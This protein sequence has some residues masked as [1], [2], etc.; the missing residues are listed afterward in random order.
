VLRYGLVLVVAWIGMMKFTSYEANG[1]QPLVAHSPLMSW[2]YSFLSVQQLS[3]ILG[4]CRNLDFHLDRVAT[5]VCKGLSLG[6][7]ATAIMFLTTLTFLF[8]PPGREPSLGGF[9]ALSAA[10]GQFPGRDIVILGAA[11]W[12][13]GEA[14]TSEAFRTW[15]SEGLTPFGQ[16]EQ[17]TG[18]GPA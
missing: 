10:V 18:T 14:W 3:D 16:K 13:L 5:L 17:S 1:I 12:L 2:M 9:P 6:S 4:N 8:S 15:A 11:I 7:A